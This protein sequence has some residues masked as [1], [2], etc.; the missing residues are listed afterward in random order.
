M[1]QDQTAKRQRIAQQAVDAATILLDQVNIMI[2]LGAEAA[3]SGN[4]IDSDLVQTGLQHLTPYMIGV[5]LGD[6][7]NSLATWAHD[8]SRLPILLQV[9]R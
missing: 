1:A 5:L 2:E 6:I 4:Y 3:Q 7:T 9:R 8:A